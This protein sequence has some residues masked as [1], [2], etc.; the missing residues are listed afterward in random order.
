MKTPVTPPPAWLRIY[1]PEGAVLEMTPL[2]T[3]DRVRLTP[4]PDPIPLTQEPDT[5]PK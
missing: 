3:V 5:W 1:V 4:R 2:G